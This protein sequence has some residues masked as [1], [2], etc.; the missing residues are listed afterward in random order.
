[1]P[2]PELEKLQ[3]ERLKKQVAYV[4]EKVP[5]YKKLYADAGVSADD[6][7]S[8]EDIAKLPF[9]VKQ[10]LRDHYPF[11][12][13]AVPM[14]EIKQIHATSG[15]TGKMTVTGYTEND[16]EVWAETMAR[17]YTAAGTT[18]DDMV[19]NAYGYA[20]FTGG[21]G[22]H[23]GARKIGAA[24]VP[25]SGGLT[26]RQVTILQDFAPSLS[27]PLLIPW[28][29]QRRPRRWGLMSIRTSSCGLASWVP[30]PGLPR[31]GRRLRRN[32]A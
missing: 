25:V 31:C 6:L 29:W 21:L 3:L 11:G 2:R 24:V 27:L 8:L 14:S 18:A 26:R 23:L 10:N 1:M 22:F 12:M 16:M 20:L 5:F 30:S 7:K 17:V 15:T 19:H 9:T 32:W 13:Y 28:C 4:T